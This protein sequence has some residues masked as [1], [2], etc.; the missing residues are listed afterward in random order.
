M[1]I[2]FDEVK[3]RTITGVLLQFGDLVEIRKLVN[4]GGYFYS[5]PCAEWQRQKTA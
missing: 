1:S 3:D 2:L 4:L 5:G